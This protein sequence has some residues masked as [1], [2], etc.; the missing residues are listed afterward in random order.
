MESNK[1]IFLYGLVCVIGFTTILADVPTPTDPK[2]AELELLLQRSQQLLQ[3]VTLV[4]K[5]VD[6]ST[7]EQVTEMKESIEQLEEEK[8]QLINEIAEVKDSIQ[9][10]IINSSPFE[11][12][13][14]VS[15]TTSR[16]K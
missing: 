2:D 7:A 16:R 8:Q 4:A 6:Q 3:K 9:S 5:Q 11:L 10:N 15:D 14:I 13:P 12:G 1:K